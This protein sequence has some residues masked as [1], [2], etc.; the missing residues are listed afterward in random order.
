MRGS[1]VTAG[2]A[3]LAV[4]CVSAL[5]PAAAPQQSSS[6]SA[7]VAA[8][9]DL[10]GAERLLKDGRW[11]EA[12]AA[13]QSLVDSAERSGNVAVE[14]RGMVGLTNVF[15]GKT[16]YAQA[17]E[18]AHRV[19]DFA[20]RAGDIGC[21]GH[22]NLLLSATAEMMGDRKEA[23]SRADEAVAAFEATDD[24]RG[25]ALATLEFI[26]VNAFGLAEIRRLIEKV[27]GDA[28][29]AGDRNIEGSAY[30]ALGD[31]EFINGEYESALASLERAA[32]VY[33]DIGAPI[34]LGTVYNSIGR[35]YRAHSR[36][37][38][39][40]DYQRK[41]L[42]LHEQGTNTFSIVQSLNAVSAMYEKLDE[43][44]KARTYVERALKLAEG[45]ESPRI[46]DFL[47]A[48]LATILS[49]QGEYEQALELLQ[50][51]IARGLDAYG[52]QRYLLLSYNLRKLG[53]GDEAVQ[54]A[55]TALER[56][57]ASE[58]EAIEG[59]CAE[60][61]HERAE[62]HL[63]R[64]EASEAL[65]DVTTAL[66][67]IENA[68]SMLLP[69]DFFKQ[70]FVL[71]REETYSLAIALQLREG[72][73]EAALDTAELA[74][75]RAFIDLLATRELQPKT[76]DALS[77]NPSPGVKAPASAYREL[78]SAA[79]AAPARASDLAGVARRLRSTLLA[80]WVADDQLFIWI[81]S[82]NGRVRTARVG[83]LES[84]LRALTRAAMPVDTTA[85][86]AVGSAKVIETRGGNSFSLDASGSNAWRELY[87]L[88]IRPVR[89]ALPAAPGS[90][91]TIVPH[92]ALVNVAFAALQDETGRYLLEDFTLHYAPAGAVLQFTAGRRRADARTGP[93]LIVADPVPAKT[94]RLDRP[95]PPL[96]GARIEARDIA[97]QLPRAR[98]TLLTGADAT[99]QHVAAAAQ[100]T[101]VVHFATH[102]V[103]RDDAPFESFLAVAPDS[104]STT[105]RMT[106]DAIYRWNLD[107]DLVVL[108]ACRSGGGRVSGDGI[109]ALARAF[110][111]A[112]A[113]S[114]IASV[115]DVADRAT[116]PLMAS[117]Y[118]SWLSGASKSRALR[119]AQLT[120]LNDL[121]AGRVIVST[122][123][124]PVA[125]PEHP[126]FWAGFSL[127]GEPR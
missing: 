5:R 50:P 103:V 49:A 56:C 54:A 2:I 107:A 101:A 117:F 53:R 1:R 64:G 99:E 9:L 84:R 32:A 112:G 111:Y 12:R 79:T 38:V 27:I 122:P 85:P 70:D 89:S 120:M 66:E 90:L 106:T 68:R 88:L 81:V 83:V 10:K 17:R 126:I 109:A 11:D 65:R 104:A 98:V 7:T 127:I 40:L 113:P 26:R 86:T 46:Q 18:S 63:S 121:R 14:C 31:V 41:A 80:Y 33:T 8:H 16:L 44:E 118:R 37:D 77:S 39:A 123:A 42:A 125:L 22:A 96:P 87:D 24:R 100:R 6:P 119:N 91:L 3:S 25:R 67:R 23:S 13:Y 110:I 47:R 78:N 59:K 72:H 61:F 60:A 102:A 15:F 51:V 20:E 94:T 82:A 21:I 114:V 69:S 95:L 75:S 62:A 28:R 97:R 71:K 19:L 116:G 48:N 93:V 105:G 36:F 45:S 92:G 4:V 35:V 52:S 30:H 29:A 115:W 58:G 55:N 124:G 43:H 34:D 73:R 74:K 57:L 108:S 76:L